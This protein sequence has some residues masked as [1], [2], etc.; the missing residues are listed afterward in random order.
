MHLS[1]C[2][3]SSFCKREEHIFCHFIIA[4]VL[5]KWFSGTQNTEN[6]HILKL[7]VHQTSEKRN[8]L[9]FLNLISFNVNLSTVRN[10]WTAA[11]EQAMI[12][13]IR[14]T[15]Q[16]EAYCC[17]LCLWGHTMPYST[18]C[19]ILAS[20]LVD[21][22]NCLNRLVSSDPIACGLAGKCSEMISSK[23]LDSSCFAPTSDCRQHGDRWR[24]NLCFWDSSPPPGDVPWP[25]RFLSDC[26]PVENCVCL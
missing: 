9:W 16:R 22:T 23:W 17:W 26:F 25:V 11:N 19:S 8:V 20:D 1:L 15:T 18:N 3:F 5:F 4:T 13:E 10:Q 7:T 21:S 12:A 6:K 2:L 24:Q 14:T